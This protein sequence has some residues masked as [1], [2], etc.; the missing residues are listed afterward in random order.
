MDEKCQRAY[1]LFCEVAQGIAEYITRIWQSFKKWL[2]ERPALSALLRRKIS[3]KSKSSAKGLFEKQHTV[4][5]YRS[6]V[7][8]RPARQ[9]ARSRC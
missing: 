1:E 3:V 7:N 9:V 8:Y 4:K 6:Q 2:F 5:V